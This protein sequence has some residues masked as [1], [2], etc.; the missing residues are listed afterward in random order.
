[1]C[2]RGNGAQNQQETLCVG[3]LGG[4]G[5]RSGEAEGE[6]YETSGTVDA[7]ETRSREHISS[8][9][10]IAYYK[11]LHAMYTNIYIYVYMYTYIHIY[12]YIYVYTYIYI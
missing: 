10:L 6:T 3:H 8:F 9:P 1:M 12:M 2:P 4:P 5:S 11:I 7:H